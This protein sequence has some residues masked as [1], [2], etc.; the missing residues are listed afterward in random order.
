MAGVREKK[1]ERE[2]EM[3]VPEST[4]ILYVCKKKK[5]AECGKTT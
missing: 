5:N 3:G 4:K 2:R 1:R